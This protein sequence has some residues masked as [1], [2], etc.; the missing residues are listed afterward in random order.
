MDGVPLSVLS[1]LEKMASALRLGTDVRRSIFVAIMSSSDCPEALERL[2]SVKGRL[3][4]EIAPVL[5]LCCARERTYNPFYAVLAAAIVRR[6]D[7]VS[8]SVSL[9][10]TLW[11]TVRSLS[12]PNAAGDAQKVANLGHLYADLLRRRALKLTALKVG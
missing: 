4:R 7:G 2:S 11:D 1:P 5:F 10:Y 12:G 9:M 6:V 3:R 8:F